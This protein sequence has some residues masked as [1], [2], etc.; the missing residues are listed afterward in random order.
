MIS[1]L[2]RSY[3]QWRATLVLDLVV[4]KIYRL[5]TGM[6]IYQFEWCCLYADGIR[7]SNLAAW[8]SLKDIVN[9]ILW[10]WHSANFSSC[11]EYRDENANLQ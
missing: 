1:L 4:Q 2:H 6:N 11:C 8:A 5:K 10:N 9:T 3:G 7:M